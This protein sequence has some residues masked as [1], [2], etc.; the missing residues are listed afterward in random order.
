MKP[1]EKRCFCRTFQDVIEKNEFFSY[2]ESTS[3]EKN[4]I[5]FQK[6]LVSSEKGR[7]FASQ[8]QKELKAIYRKW[9]TI[10]L[11]NV[12]NLLKMGLTR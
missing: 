6:N 9:K 4:S 8:K 1:N 7:I 11:V 10:T 2:T 3:Y 5:F 12:R